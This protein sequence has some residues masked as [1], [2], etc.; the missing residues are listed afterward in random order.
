MGLTLPGVLGRIFAAASS[1]FQSSQIAAETWPSYVI[2]GDGRV[3]VSDGSEDTTSGTL[4][5]TDPTVYI[6]ARPNKLGLVL[7]G[8]NGGSIRNILEIQDFF[9]APIWSV[10]N[11][12]GM[13]L[14]D[15]LKVAFSAN[16][17]NNIFGDI[18][19][20]LQLGA[21][22]AIRISA[23][24]PGNIMSFTDATG[25]LFQRARSAQQGSWTAT[26][27]TWSGFDS[28]AGLAPSGFRYSRAWTSV[29]AGNIVATTGTGTS[30]YP[31]PPNTY[32]AAII[33][34][35]AATVARSKTLGLLFYNAVGTVI[36]SA[37]V[38]AAAADSTSG[39]T[40]YTVQALS[41]S[42]TAFCA[43]Q[44]TITGTAA[45]GEVHYSACA[46]IWIGLV[47]SQVTAW[48]APFVYRT[49]AFGG[50]NATGLNDGANVGD[51]FIRADGPPN[52][53]QRFWTNAAAGKPWQQNWVSDPRLT[54]S[55]S[56]VNWYGGNYLQQGQVADPDYV[57]P[58]VALGMLHNDPPDSV[59]RGV[60]AAPPAFNLLNDAANAQAFG[61]LAGF[62]QAV[63]KKTGGAP[64][65]SK[66]GMF[67]FFYGLWDLACTTSGGGSGMMSQLNGY[68]ATPGGATSAIINT[69]RDIIV[70]ARASVILPYTN[71]A[72]SLSGN[73]TSGAVQYAFSGG[74][75]GA[76]G[77]FAY[78][79]T[80][81]GASFTFTIPADFAG[82]AV[83]IGLLGAA[84]AFGGT[85]TWTG[86][87]FSTGGIT[88]PGPTSVS[89]VVPVTTRGRVVV[90]FKG[91]SSANAGQT[92]IGTITAVDASGSVCLDCAYLEGP[93]PNLVAVFG[94]PKLATAAAYATLAG[95][96]SYW[97][98]NAGATGDA[99]VATLN[100]SLQSLVAEFDTS[101]FYVDTDGAMQK[102]ASLFA[103]D[104]CT[105]NAFGVHAMASQYINALQAQLPL[106]SFR[107]VN[108][109]YHDTSVIPVGTPFSRPGLLSPTTGVSRFYADDYYYLTS[110]RASVGTA[111]AGASL[112]VDVLKN[113][114]TIFTTSGNRPAI[115]PGAFTAV[116]AAPPDL[117]FLVPGD[118]LTV[119]IAQ[120]GSAVPGADLTV[121][122][123]GRKI[124]I[125]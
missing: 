111:P 81:T 100:A 91:L 42:N 8:E 65:V 20:H 61:G 48:N 63:R 86:T 99:D 68:S 17:P 40:T 72:F 113:G 35:R 5:Y 84:G 21:Q 52:V 124:P 70:H 102:Q 55:P 93:Y 83:S 77:T 75:P 44:E 88:N 7:R 50:V 123:L 90:R 46:G 31:I 69:L 119:N 110:V 67:C 87:L 1:L 53:V 118:Y 34:T 47:S 62:L 28:G 73:L 38:G 80:T 56:R 19:G 25:E 2:M 89:N 101:C 78:W 108:H 33:K 71:A 120:T 82:T 32:I 92:I 122:V 14:N 116:S 39:W 66:D 105:L 24:P 57:L 22:S 117:L 41:P 97:N 16:G 96:G 104:G 27:A 15:N 4:V 6:R 115:A 45:A 51:V 103:A 36:G 59:N 121:N 94:S 109:D 58:S 18:Y 37:V 98:S 79:T 54:S 30:G 43:L 95:A 76:G 114:S 85:V 64:Y 125:P 74:G 12:G 23:G 60:I 29:A 9:G 3:R 106:I 11:A 49:D 26:N 107:N 13:Y 112:I 10:L